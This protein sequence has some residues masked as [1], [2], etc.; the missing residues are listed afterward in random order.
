MTCAQDE[1]N[2]ICH[3]LVPVMKEVKNATKTIQTYRTVQ[4]QYNVWRVPEFHSS[5]HKN[6]PVKAKK[7]QSYRSL[8]SCFAFSGKM[9]TLLLALFSIAISM[10]AS[11]ARESELKVG[12]G[13]TLYG[14]VCAVRCWTTSCCS[15]HFYCF[16]HQPFRSLSYFGFH[17]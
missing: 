12:T 2:L 3:N 9:G 13:T 11:A 17:E 6:S 8:C 10:K 15:H 4:Y 14:E 5:H 7:P 1:I 16:T